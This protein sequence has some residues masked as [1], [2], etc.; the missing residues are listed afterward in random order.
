[1]AVA[2]NQL[3]KTGSGST[4]QLF[5][6]ALGAAA[7]V[8]LA[9]GAGVLGTIMVGRGAGGAVFAISFAALAAIAFAQRRG[10]AARG[11]GSESPSD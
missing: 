9:V 5:P 7:V 10:G 11:F 6:G 8:V 3:R 1:M 2:F 4:R